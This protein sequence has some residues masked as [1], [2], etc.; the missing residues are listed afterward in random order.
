MNTNKEVKKFKKD[1]EKYL[2][3]AIFLESFT[4]FNSFGKYTSQNVPLVK[5]GYEEYIYPDISNLKQNDKRR[6]NLEFKNE[7]TKVYL[8]IKI[9][10]E[11]LEKDDWYKKESFDMSLFVQKYVEFDFDR[12][13]AR[14][15]DKFKRSYHLFVEGYIKTTYIKIKYI[16]CDA[17]NSIY[18]NNENNMKIYENYNSDEHSDF[19][20]NAKA[21]ND[22]FNNFHFKIFRCSLS[23]S[24][25]RERFFQELFFKGDQKIGLIYYELTPTL[26]CKGLELS[27]NWFIKNWKFILNLVFSKF[28]LY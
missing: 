11:K 13:F 7:E 23:N 16:R 26:T 28:E 17:A 10:L 15:L 18:Y 9:N 21:L 19:L 1:Y 12:N 25:S 22:V 24:S 3:K 6:K 4:E 8:N 14:F 27:K 5:H 2:L 20:N